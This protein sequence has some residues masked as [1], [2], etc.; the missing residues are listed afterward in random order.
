MDDTAF[1]DTN[2]FLRFFVKDIAS[3]Y[4]KARALFEKA[5][6]GKIKLETN[7]LVIAEIVWVLE[8]FYGFTR[9][10]ITEVLTTLLASR[11]LKI[12]NHAKVAHATGLYSSG[13]M[14]FIDAYNIAYIRSKEYTKVATF[15]VR[16]Y[17]KAEG[18]IVIL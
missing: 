2:V 7:E 1:V 9:K 4:E 16:H 14:D 6:N 17:K 12:A 8:S 11:N 5:E 10:E 3:Q 13:N 15:D 18:T